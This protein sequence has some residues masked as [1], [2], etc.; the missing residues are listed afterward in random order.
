MSTFSSNYRNLATVPVRAFQ[1]PRVLDPNAAEQAGE[2]EPEPEQQPVTAE[3]TGPAI[4]ENDLAA[5]YEKGRQEA[6]REAEQRT[7]EQLAA[8]ISAER[9]RVSKAIE[10]FQQSCSDYYGKVEDEVVHLSLG[11]AA[12][13]LH[14]EAQ[15]DPLLVAAL[16]RVATE[17]LKQGSKVQ[18]N[19]HPQEIRAWKSYF[20]KEGSGLVTIELA[21]DP[22]LAPGECIVHSEV[23]VAALG[24]DSQLKEIERGLFDLLAQRP[25]NE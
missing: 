13:I 22:T 6:R 20:E 1:Y 10:D 21:E 9:E 23:G 12:K 14:R 11:I 25:K 8:T 17:N 18:V 15:V 16:V 24:L 4:T 2:A 5:A 3:P 19:I 7:K